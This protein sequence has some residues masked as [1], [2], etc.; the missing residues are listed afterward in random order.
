MIKLTLYQR[1]SLSRI[2]DHPSHGSSSMRVHEVSGDHHA[3]EAVAQPVVHE[4]LIDMLTCKV[5]EWG[6]GIYFATARSEDFYPYAQLY[7]DTIVSSARLLEAG[8]SPGD[9][10][11]FQVADSRVLI[12]LFWA[13]A[14]VGA[15]PALLPPAVSAA[16]TVRVDRAAA[17]MPQ[18]AILAD[19]RTHSLLERSGSADRIVR[20]SQLLVDQEGDFRASLQPAEV[21]PESE[22]LIQFSSGSTGLP[23]GIIVTERVLIGTLQTTLPQHGYRFQ[24]SMLTWLPLAHNLSLVGFH[25]NSVSQDFDQIIM[26]TVDFLANPYVWME[27]ITRHRPTVTVCPNFGM[28]HFLSYVESRPPAEGSSYDL[29]S[30]QKVITGAEPIDANVA[31]EFQRR[32]RDYGLQ[33]NTIWTGYGMSEACLTI[34]T[35]ELRS[36]LRTIQLDR[37]RITTGARYADIATGDGV[38]FVSVGRVAPSITLTIRDDDATVIGNGVV[39]EIH[40]QGPTITESA[41]TDKGTVRHAVTDDGAL[42]TGDMG[43]LHDGELYVIGRRKE[44][45]FVNGKNYYSPD[46]ERIIWENAAIDTVVIGR[47]NPDTG[48]EDVVVYVE[49]GEH[50]DRAAVERSL[51][52]ALMRV[53]GVPTTQVCWIDSIPV[54][55]NGKKLRG[56]VGKGSTVVAAQ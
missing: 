39:G 8:I 7:R 45:I 9:R 42:P 13:C 6:R 47:S 20:T 40:L 22:R 37:D 55:P 56:L 43:M 3:G 35:A 34:S 2:P 31:G 30:V 11:L 27:A 1:V 38:R 52:S 24:N 23:K 44:I 26:P 51:T 46:L 10:V 33:E 54:A 25:V 28:K 48:G 16:D 36:E 17:L 4:A 18:A 15:V 49:R 21:G 53:A 19:E 32:L 50:G 12:R 5:E 41:I 14:F 29:S